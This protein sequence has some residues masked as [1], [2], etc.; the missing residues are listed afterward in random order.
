MVHKVAS[1]AE[2]D[3][4]ISKDSL[5]TSSSSL[6]LFFFFC[7]CC[8]CCYC[9]SSPICLPFS[10]FCTR[11]LWTT[12]RCGV[13]P[14]RPS[15]LTWTPS[16]R[17]TPMSPSLRSMS[18]SSRYYTPCPLLSL[19]HFLMC[20]RRPWQASRGSPPC[21]PSSSSRR[22]PS[23]TSSGEPTRMPSRLLSSNTSDPP[24]CPLTPTLS[25]I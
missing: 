15:P 24:P 17:R 9:C 12:L 14:A 18:M 3:S 8:C 11:W 16:P 20:S 19:L 4:T 21:P 22:D 7:C 13:V 5:V 10:F 23:S 6:F 25:F 2:F 1:E